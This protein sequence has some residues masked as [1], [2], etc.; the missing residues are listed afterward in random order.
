MMTPLS[1]FIWKAIPIL[2]TAQFSTRLMLLLS[3]TIS[4]ISIYLVTMFKKLHIFIYLILAITIAY[5]VLNWGHR[6]IIPQITDSTLAANLPKSTSEGEGYCCM[7]QPKWT[8]P[9]AEWM[10][11][12]PSKHIEVV[13]GQG[14]IIEEYRL[15]N[16][17]NFL[18]FSNQEM[19]IKENTWYFPGWNLSIDGKSTKIIYTNKNYPDIMFFQV[20]KG[21]HTVRL[22]YKDLPELF[23][24]KVVSVLSLLTAILLIILQNIIPPL[25]K[26]LNDV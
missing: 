21:L 18:T 2:N 25:K 16:Q 6:R 24:A 7:A 13:K 20:P 3:F 12:V 17:H 19:L 5:T 23:I 10:S 4:A 11:I 15:N 8:L 9:K 14:K 26:R 1:A 22:E